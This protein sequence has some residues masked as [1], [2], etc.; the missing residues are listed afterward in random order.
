M[1]IQ[2]DSLK[3]LGF[4]SMDMVFDSTVTMIQNRAAG[5]DRPLRTRWGKLNGYWNGG[6]EKIY[7][8][9]ILLFQ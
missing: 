8:L 5:I 3:L 9:N 6:V 7:N 1:A 4:K 2:E